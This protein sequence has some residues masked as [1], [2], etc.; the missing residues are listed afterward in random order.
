[1]MNNEKK[2]KGFSDKNKNAENVFIVSFYIWKTYGWFRS[3]FV[4]KLTAESL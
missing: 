1:M 2:K 4:Q 3:F